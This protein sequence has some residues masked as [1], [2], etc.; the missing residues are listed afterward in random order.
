MGNINYIDKSLHATIAEYLRGIDPSV[1]LDIYLHEHPDQSQASMAKPKFGMTPAAFGKALKRAG[2]HLRDDWVDVVRSLMSGNDLIEFERKAELVFRVQEL[3]NLQTQRESLY[4][5][6]PGYLQNLGIEPYFDVVPISAFRVLCYR[7]KNSPAIWFF[8]LPHERCGVDGKYEDYSIY[9]KILEHYNIRTT[10]A[11]CTTTQRLAARN[12]NPGL[13]SKPSAFLQESSQI[14][15]FELSDDY[16]EVVNTYS[17]PF[18]PSGSDD[19]DE[20][21]LH[22]S[23][24]LDQPSQ[25]GMRVLLEELG[26]ADDF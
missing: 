3:V 13:P 22:V 17:S 9:T 2:D 16:S 25:D 1:F 4:S 11:I 12:Q 5:W 19:E 23:L 20:L 26:L 10:L 24:P 14:V 7:D 6:I 15:L 18:L 21:P 8:I